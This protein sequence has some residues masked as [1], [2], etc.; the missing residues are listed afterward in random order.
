MK[1]LVQIEKT[2]DLVKISA[3]PHRQFDVYCKHL[4]DKKKSFNLPKPFSLSIVFFNENSSIP[5]LKT[6]N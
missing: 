2:P 1:I 3:H 5:S 6:I 4:M